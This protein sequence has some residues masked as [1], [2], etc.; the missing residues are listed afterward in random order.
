MPRV[1]NKQNIVISTG[2][3]QKDGVEKQRYKTIGE[4]LTM[5][6]DDGSQYQFGEM[7]GPTGSQ[8]FNVYEQQDRNQQRPQQ[9]APQSA[10]QE[11]DRSPPQQSAPPQQPA[12]QQF[13]ADDDF[14][15]SDVPF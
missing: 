12:P 11:F 6:G 15:S 5:E 4:L 8:K 14:D 10:A 7:W 3:Y 2:T 1:I 13:K 9:Q